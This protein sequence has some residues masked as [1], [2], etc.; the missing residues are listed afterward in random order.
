M[1]YPCK[2]QETYGMTDFLQNAEILLQN[3]QISK[4]FTGPIRLLGKEW[5]N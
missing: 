5:L 3:A 4:I 2:G 1:E